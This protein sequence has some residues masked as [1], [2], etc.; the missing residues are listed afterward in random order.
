MS[1]RYAVYFSPRADEGLAVFARAW[2]GRDPER[3]RDVAQIVPDG[4]SQTA[5]AEITAEPRRY[6]FHGT[7]KAPFALARG[8]TADALLTFAADFARRRAPFTIPHLD[9][10]LLDGFLAL[11]P[12]QQVP[13]LDQ[14]A[15]DCVR[16]FDLFRAPLDE[17][18]LARRR[19]AGLT[20][21]QEAALVRWGYPYVLEDFRFHLT[22]TGRLDEPERG[23]IRDILMR[24]MAPYLEVPL[25]VRDLVVFAQDDRAA[26]FRILARFSLAGGQR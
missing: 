6:G 13:E 17:A 14:L 5:L 1:A 9:L 11:V 2:L 26:P 23:R 12:A 16:E 25:Q 24:L 7:L 20:A 10:A 4:L 3:D 22:L 21:R 18:D 19:Q 15:A 8:A